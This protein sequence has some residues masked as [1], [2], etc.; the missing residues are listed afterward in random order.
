MERKTFCL[1]EICCEVMEHIPSV[2]NSKSAYLRDIIKF[3]IHSGKSLPR[4]ITE[5]MTNKSKGN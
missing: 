4:P 5:Y 1:D 2:Y 3:Y